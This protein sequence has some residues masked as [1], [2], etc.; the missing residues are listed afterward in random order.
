MPINLT[1]KRRPALGTDS[2]VP[3]RYALIVS[4]DSTSAR[5]CEETLRRMRFEIGRM[6]SGVAAVVAARGRVPALIF[7]DLQLPDASASETIG[8]LRANQALVAVPIV[9]LGSAG[10]SGLPNKGI[11]A[12]SKPPSSVA[13]EQAV[14]DLC[15]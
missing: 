3:E 9:V 11:R 15:G 5:R 6:N 10:G 14:R 4:G 1:L 2:R 7:M 8:W 13:I 12:I